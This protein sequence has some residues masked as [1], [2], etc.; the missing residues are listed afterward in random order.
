MRVRR[1]DRIV[2][3]PFDLGVASQPV[4]GQRDL[5][6]IARGDQGLRKQRIGVQR[7]PGEQLPERLRHECG[8]LRAT[9]ANRGERSG[10]ASSTNATVASIDRWTR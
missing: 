3:L 6:G 4:C 7:N 9:V 10:P 1:P 2:P 5:G 8:L